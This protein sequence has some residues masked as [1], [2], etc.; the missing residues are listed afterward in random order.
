M[1]TFLLQA[2][3]L[4]RWF[5]LLFLLASLFTCGI[6]LLRNKT[7][8]KS[9][10]FLRHTTATA[11]H[12]QLMIGLI[13]YTQSPLVKAFFKHAAPDLFFAILHPSLMFI[14]ILILSVVSAKAK[15][16]QSDHQKFRWILWGYGL[17]LILIFVAIPW[18]FSP[19]ANRPYLRF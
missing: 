10:N 9:H 15:R 11:A 17:A 12:I 2:H 8:S 4:F 13:L 6:A 3:N 5:V 1:Y 16:L 19:I 7:F 14:A 18:P